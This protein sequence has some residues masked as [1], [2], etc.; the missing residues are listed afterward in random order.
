MKLQIIINTILFLTSS[1]CSIHSNEL[2]LKPQTLEHGTNELEFIILI[3]MLSIISLSAII[4]CVFKALSL[5]KV[6]SELLEL[7]HRCQ[8][9]TQNLQLKITQLEQ[10]KHNLNKTI[11]A[12]A[13][14]AK[15]I[16]DAMRKKLVILNNLIAKEI[17]NNND[18]AKSYQ[19]IVDP[20]KTDKEKFLSKTRHAFKETYPHFIKHLENQGLSSFEISYLCLYAIGLSGK[21]IGEYIQLKRHYNVSSEIRKKLNIKEN[22]TTLSSYVKKFL[23]D[24]Q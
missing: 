12:N 15:E 4:A 3:T 6:Q 19:E 22:S 11:Q 2:E 10:D 23:Y 24:Q 20:I 18:Y 13:M 9:E 5:R 1:V 21:E 7:K 14:N 8:T 16:Q 17:T